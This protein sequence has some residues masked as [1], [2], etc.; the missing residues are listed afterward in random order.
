[1]K[2]SFSKMKGSLVCFCYSNSDYIKV[3]KSFKEKLDMFK[4]QDFVKIGC[5]NLFDF[6]W[7]Y[8]F[9]AI[10]LSVVI[11]TLNAVLEEI[12]LYIVKRLGYDQRTKEAKIS[13]RFLFSIYY[14]NASIA[15]LLIG[16][17]L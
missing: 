11:I 13:K 10:K 7:H 14:F 8:L 17:N 1:M 9:F 15:I 2:D 3:P 16:A 6:K 4:N 5:K 12:I